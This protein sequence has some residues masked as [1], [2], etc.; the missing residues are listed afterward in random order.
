KLGEESVTM[1]VTLSYFVQSSPGRRGWTRKH[2]YASHGLRFDLQKP[3]ESRGA[4]LRRISDAALEDPEEGVDVATGD[5]LPWVVGKHGRGQ[6]SLHC[7]WW[8]GTAVEL[9]SCRHLA[10]Y[11]VTGWWRERA[12]L[13]RWKE[14]VRYSLIVSIQT[15]NTAIY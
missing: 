9:E 1:R 13:K 7:D 11:L 15:S 2:R 3:A 12:H 8:S 6:G 14:S 10:V 5:S 4:F